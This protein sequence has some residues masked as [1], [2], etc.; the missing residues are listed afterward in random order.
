MIAIEEGVELVRR[1]LAE[2]R[3]LAVLITTG[4][5]HEPQVAVVNATVVAHPVTGAAVV[6]FVGRRGAK[7]VNL[8][9]QPQ[10]TLVARAGWEWVAVAGDVELSGPDD[11][12]DD[13]DP[14]QQRHL[15]R[16]IYTAAGGHHPDLDVYDRTMLDERRCAVLIHPVR[17]WSNPAGSEHLEPEEQ[18]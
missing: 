18:P 6:A 14:E 1:R 15:L 4:Q 13:I 5:H 11:P 3:H 7:L 8:R 9:R 12:H 2:D 17:I 10:A 16:D